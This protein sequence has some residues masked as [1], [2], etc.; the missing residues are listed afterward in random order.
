MLTV[1]FTQSQFE[2]LKKFNPGNDIVNVESELFIIGAKKSEEKKLLKKIDKI[3]KGEY[4]EKKLVNINT[5]MFYKNLFDDLPELVIPEKLAIIAGQVVGYTMPFIYP[6]TNLQTILRSSDIP[7]EDKIKYLKK[8]GSLLDRMDNIKNFPH[9]FRLGDLH[10][11]NFII[12]KNDNLHV[13][14]LDS[15][16]ISNNKCFT[17]KY[18][19]LNPL[20]LDFL[21]KY[22]IDEDRDIIPSKNTD[23]YCYIMIILNTLAR[24]DMFNLSII[25][26]YN[27][28]NY[29]EEIGIN[30]DLLFCI[31]KIYHSGNNENPLCYLDEIPIKKAYEAHHLVYKKR[32]G[33]DLTKH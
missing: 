25:Q 13:V 21:Y 29:L 11:A 28:I 16:Y 5:L 8:I 19:F 26:F 22:K 20:L 18:L 15:S 3:D 31:E 2:K 27:Y 6:N 1:S 4:M 33:H 7:I 32:T 17:S 12:D 24:Y 9:E 14:D 10:E 30:K 23:I